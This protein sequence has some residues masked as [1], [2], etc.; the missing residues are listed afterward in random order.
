MSYTPAPQEPD[1]PNRPKRPTTARITIWI[2]VAAVG[3]YF[4]GTG[5]YGI[6]T[7]GN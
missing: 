5:I 2:V 6:V 1:D 7:G 3:L 4:L